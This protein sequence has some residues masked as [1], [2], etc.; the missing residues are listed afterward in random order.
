MISDVRELE[1]DPLSYLE[2]GGCEVCSLD[3]DEHR[4]WGMTDFDRLKADVIDQD[5]CMQCGICVGICPVNVLE[6][7]DDLHPLPTLVSDGACINCTLCVRACPREHEHAIEYSIPLFGRMPEAYELSGVVKE[8]YAGH[9]VD[10][11]L[12]TAAAGGGLVSGLTIYLLEK[13]IVDGVIMCGMSETEPWKAIPKIVHTREEMLVNTSSHY[14]TVPINQILQVIRRKPEKRYALV[15]TACHINGIRNMQF[16]PG[17]G[18]EMVKQIELTIGLMCGGNRIPKYTR[19][20]LND[21][22]ITD[23]DDVTKFSYRGG[24]SGSATAHLRNGEV[25]STQGHF[26]SDIRRLDP[27]HEAGGCTLCID[28]FANLAD[29]TIGDYM[30]KLSVG[31][32]RSDL[33]VQVMQGAAKAGHIDID[34]IAYGFDSRRQD[35]HRHDVKKRVAYTLIDNKK[36]NGLPYPNYGFWFRD[37]M[38]Y[39]RSDFDRRFFI[40]LRWLAKQ[41]WFRAIYRCLPIRLQWGFGVIW[42]SRQLFSKEETW[43]NWSGFFGKLPSLGKS[44]I[45]NELLD[46]VLARQSKARAEAGLS[47]DDG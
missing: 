11:E 41:R 16:A 20:L 4:R 29:I 21:M 26:G 13:K 33:G 14:V 40:F 17:D 38:P 44:E 22:K 18:R 5:M 9:I 19:H 36:S 43:P 34:P 6:M 8:T 1:N 37:P 47:K 45:T 35:R 31:F 46:K 25:R 24:A 15:G 2:N 3:Y 28:F 42:A 23:T 30:R 39:W 10:R 32:A 7:V 27:L 12:W